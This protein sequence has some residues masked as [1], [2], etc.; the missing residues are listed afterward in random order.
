MAEGKIPTGIVGLDKLLK[1]G[2]LPNASIMIEGTPG[3]GKSTLALQM[4]AEGIAIGEPG[5]IVTLEEYPA[6]YYR[7]ALNYGWDLKKWE[8]EDVVRVVAT[9]PQALKQQVETGGPLA[10]EIDAIGA[11]RI[12]VDSVNQFERISSDPSFL[13]TTL[14]GLIHAFKIRD[15]VSIFTKDIEGMGAL[16]YWGRYSVDVL[17][18]LSFLLMKDR[19]RHRLMEIHKAR[20][21]SHVLGRHSF[22][23]TDSGIEI[24][25]RPV[26]ESL[27]AVSGRKHEVARIGSGIEGFDE[28]LGGGYITGQSILVAGGAGTGK[29]LS[30]ASFC[31]VEGKGEGGALYVSLEDPPAKVIQN[32]LAA[33]IDL[34]TGVNEGHIELI[35]LPPIELS[36]DELLY[37]VES[38]LD[39][40]RYNRLVID[41]VS[42]LR[43][44]SPEQEYLHDIVF[45][46]ASTCF[47]RNIVGILTAEIPEVT[48]PFRFSDFGGSFTADGVILHRLVEVAGLLKKAISII[49]MRG[50]SHDPSL[51][52]LIIGKDGLRIGPAF[53]NLTGLLTGTPT[54]Q[55]PIGFEAYMG[56]ATQERERIA[57]ALA[58]RKEASANEVAEAAGMDLIRTRE[59]LELL[60][61]TG[62]VAKTK[63]NGEVRYRSTLLKAR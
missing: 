29:S 19:E 36:P 52:E 11:K 13:R 60:A 10:D 22:K 53:E 50:S 47:R 16:Q 24:F 33:G 51:R 1:G 30:A 25:P 31:S 4:I 8:K 2:V 43:S 14:S 21:Q 9:S 42:S 59:I 44:V 26:T 20:G 12:A 35:Y 5:V 18:E 38:R 63:T 55:R 61:E 15:M 49:K 46:I 32:A 56:E 6:E 23:I 27:V 58:E 41:S 37:A 34:Q 7:D 48:G 28:M 62:F 3:T 54:A 39:S 45:A 57:A 40:G 17:I